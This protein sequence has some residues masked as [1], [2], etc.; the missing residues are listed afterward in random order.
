MHIKGLFPPEK[1]GYF[2]NLLEYNLFPKK[3]I[4]EDLCLLNKEGKETPVSVTTSQA[5]LSDKTILQYVF[6]DITQR[7]QME[8]QL[9]HA[10]KMESVGQLAAGIA[11]EI[12][13]PLQFIGNNTR[14]LQNSFDDLIEVFNEY[15]QLI[16]KSKGRFSPE[17]LIKKIIT[18]VKKN[19]MEILVDEIPEA[20]NHSLGG[21]ERVSKIV[22]PM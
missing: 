19:D 10:Q 17:E 22:Q 20:I 6:R 7:K 18:K 13:T 16:E 15:N 3:E 14:F 11:H 21:I 8:M 5:K 2:F 12:N 1:A 9:N 4:L